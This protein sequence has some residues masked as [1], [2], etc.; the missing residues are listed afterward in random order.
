[1]WHGRGGCTTFGSHPCHGIPRERFPPNYLKEQPVSNEILKKLAEATSCE[2]RAD[3]MTRQLYAT[4]ASI[5]QV[6]PQAVAFPKNAQETASV[7]E[8]AIA[9]KIPVIA[10]GAGTG[11][12]G[13][14]LGEGLVVDFS[15]HH[16][17][18]TDLNV[19]AR[20]VRVGA[21]VVL[22]Q[23]NAF[24]R[25]HGLTFG[26]DVA[27]SSRATLGGMIA[28]DSSGA[29][30]P[31]YGTTIDHTRAIEL[32]LSDGRVA[33]LGNGSA[34][35]AEERAKIEDILEACAPEV[36]RRFHDNIIKRW[37]G[38]GFRRYLKEKGNLAR[39][40]GGSEGTLG[41]VISA[42]VGLVPLPREK[43]MGLIFF[44]SI[45]EA[46]QAT[47]E[48]ADL[49]PAAIEHIDDVCFDETRGQLQFE[50][51]RALLEL[52]DKPCTSVLLVE[53]Y[54]DVREKLAAL[55]RKNLGLRKY[56]CRNDRE[57]AS[58]WG[59][60]KAGLSLLTGRAGP[61]KPVA[62]IEDVAVPPEKLPDYV[63]G[64]QDLLG[65]LGV[66]GSFYGH[67]ASGMLHVR[68]ILDLHKTMD[69]GKYRDITEGVFALSLRFNG[70]Y[71]GEHGVGLGR[72]EFMEGQIGPELLDAMRRVK[73]VLD[74]SG[75]MNPGKI[76]PDGRYRIDRDLR[77]GERWALDRLPF[78]PV[79][80]FVEKDASFVGNLEQCNGCGG[81]RKDEPTMCPT[82]RVTGED[83][84][85]TRGRANVIRAVL[86]R[87]LDFEREPLLSESLEKA[88]D[89]CLACKACTSEC[90]SNVN[91][92]LL[93]TELMYAKLRKHGVPL[94]ARLVSRL[95]LVS[96]V[97]SMAPRVTN[98]FLE[99]WPVRKIMQLT[100]G[101]SMK[102]SM[103]LY[104]R[105][106]FDRWFRKRM[107]PDKPATRGRVILWDDCYV[108]HYEPNI[109][110]AAVRVLE[111]AGF[112]VVLPEGRAC[113]GRPAFSMGRL[114]VV[115]RFAKTNMRVFRDGKAP[116]IFL[117]PSCFSMFKQDYAELRVEGAEAVAGRCFTF[118]DFM[119]NLLEKEPEALSFTSMNRA[120][121]I[122]AHCHAKAL[123][124]PERMPQLAGM[125]PKN[126]V[127]L[128]KTGCCG[129]AGAFGQMDKKYDLSVKVGRELVDQ[130]NALDPGTHVIASGTSCRHQIEHLTDFKPLHMAELLAGVLTEDVGDM[131]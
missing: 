82:Y 117:E 52:D 70:S 121:A 1:M 113:C 120:T 27:T 29:R 110:R 74:P 16:R 14:A 63:R 17:A 5:H 33:T 103:P 119:V 129:M 58:V 100:C 8:A 20:T 77:Q 51:V 89:N 60:R 67:A 46:M 107:A 56:I 37:P 26:P 78:A 127:Q 43:G 64:L 112:E 73:A 55:E 38:Y 84:M 50:A 99:F 124:K 41:A 102:R 96:K 123:T 13:G 65:P 85:A 125:I 90:P 88:L 105:Q 22:D 36:R 2:V 18:I 79:L 94:H 61:A 106:R 131:P 44:D 87:R 30:A 69:I 126:D 9:E 76:I 31:L 104:A 118:E 35:L 130:L 62:G 6:T 19:E 116:I 115:E 54:D 101:F 39:L 128:L 49:G 59:L 23:L 3:D 34:D 91:M 24:L 7:I 32:A 86:E 93:K 75:L 111:A 4:D 92:T 108:R 21:G 12:A 95:D 10:R 109:G 98:F 45:G 15:L 114:D 53:F 47:V 71:A 48:L 122:H 97:A 81:C 68:P 57:M 40:F 72:T 80:G 42:E 66:K 83:I 25:P 28:N 11:L